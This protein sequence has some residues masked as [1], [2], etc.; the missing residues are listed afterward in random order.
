MASHRTVYPLRLIKRDYSYTTGEVADTLGTCSQTVLRWVSEGLKIVPAT[1][2]YLIHSSDLFTFLEV[3]QAKRKHPCTPTQFFCC[4]CR[5]AKEASKGS[6]SVHPTRSRM[7][8][9]KGVC[10]ACGGKMN[11]VVKP[12]AW[13]PE[14]PLYQCM[15]AAV[16]Q[17]NGTQPAQRECSFEQGGQLCLNLT[18]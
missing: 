12:S 4:R 7:M 17:H 6:L 8:H 3:R 11:K 10:E 1:R 14:H 5:Q 2:P 13:G 18:R 9:L 16:Q 15:N